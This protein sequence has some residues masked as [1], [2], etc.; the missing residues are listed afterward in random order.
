MALALQAILLVGDPWLEELR[1]VEVVLD[2]A[3][4]LRGAQAGR[5]G[6]CC[7]ANIALVSLFEED[8]MCREWNPTIP[9]QPSGEVEAM[10]LE[11]LKMLRQSIW[12]PPMDLCVCRVMKRIQWKEGLKGSSASACA[13]AFSAIRQHFGK[14]L[15]ILKR[16][17]LFAR[18]LAG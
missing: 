18:Q 6:D 11:A 5:L 10:F 8:V 9:K 15:K 17:L 13:P 14:S 7:F 3:N 2:I 16:N 1:R 12:R 4:D